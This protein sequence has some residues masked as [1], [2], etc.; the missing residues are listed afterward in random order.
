MTERRCAVEGCEHPHDAGGLCRGHRGQRD[1]GVPFTRLRE[2]GVG[3]L[4]VSLRLRPE[5]I[6]ALRALS[7]T[8]GA[9]VTARKILESAT[10]TADLG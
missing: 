6:E 2:I 9:S 4:P 3:Y 1:R 8:Q 5:T 7:T 10:G